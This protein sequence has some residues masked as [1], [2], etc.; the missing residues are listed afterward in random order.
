MKRSRSKFGLM[1]VLGM[2][3]ALLPIGAV[4]PALGAS[5]GDVVINEIIQNPAAV[6][7]ADGEWFEVFNP[8]DVGVDM[9]G[10][11]IQD[12]DSD[13][14]LIDNGGPLVVPAGGYLVLGINAD[15]PTN[16]GVTVGYEYTGI[17]LANGGDEVVLLDAVL[18]EIDRVEY[19]GGPSFPDPTGA[20]MALDDPAND[21]NVGANWCT[22][23]T[24]FGDGDLG[25]PGSENDCAAPPT[26]GA[27]ADPAVLVHDV[28]GSGS[29]SPLDGQTV[30]LEAIVVGD[31]QQYDGGLD[32][33]PLDGFMIQEEDADADTDPS[34][35]EGVFVYDPGGTD[36]AVG[37]L[38]RVRG[39]VSEFFGLTEVSG[40]TDLA[41]CSSGNPAP[42]PA[43]PI[44]P[45]NDSK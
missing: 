19:D 9:H 34:T 27:C 10:W 15:G 32:D 1:L 37:D 41:V 31:F 3:A 36:V 2:L 11:T 22:S 26:F 4:A 30:E 23:S 12:N 14:H 20:S 24:P 29:A 25:T 38:V 6:A 13:S 44:V 28:Q 35:S 21:N 43:T 18:T 39:T 40:L 16:G 42:T 33:E 17:T 7:D 8:T 5:P 45:T